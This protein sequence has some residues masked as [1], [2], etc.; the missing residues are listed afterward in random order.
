[1]YDLFIDQYNGRITPTDLTFVGDAAG[2]IGRKKDFSCSDR[3][4]AYNIKAVFKTPEEFFENAAP[5]CLNK[6][7]LVTF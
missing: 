4:F 7:L 3:A 5:V 6:E 1:M 2:R